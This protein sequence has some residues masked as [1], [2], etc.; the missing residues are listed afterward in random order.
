[1]YCH[2]A[3]LKSPLIMGTDITLM[4]PQTLSIYSNPAILAISQDPLGMPAFRVWERPGQTENNTSSADLYSANT[5]SFWTGKLNGGDQVVAFVNAGPGA[6]SMIASMEDVFV[7]LVT[8]GS[9]APV[10]QLMQTWDVY[11]LWANRM[12]DVAA[13]AF[14]NGTATG[15]GTMAFNTTMSATTFN[16]TEMSYAKGLAANNT[17]LLGLKTMTIAAMGTMQVQVPSHGVAAY[18]LRSQGG[19]MMQKRDEL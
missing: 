16:S 13:Q 7:D 14:I 3:L 17:A 12:S 15:N 5:T 8:T 9:S 19:G 11:D 2:R 1:M 10:P 4:T 6:T 18:R